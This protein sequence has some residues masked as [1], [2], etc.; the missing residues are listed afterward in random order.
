MLV[1][2]KHKK[3]SAAILFIMCQEKRIELTAAPLGIG[4]FHTPIIRVVIAPCNKQT[5]FVAP[6]RSL[7]GDWGPNNEGTTTQKE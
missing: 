1:F 5:L 7:L 2:F 4:V 3:K 6:F